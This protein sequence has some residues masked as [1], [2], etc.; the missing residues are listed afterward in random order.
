MIQGTLNHAEG[1]FWFSCV[2]LQA[3]DDFQTNNLYFAHVDG[4]KRHLRNGICGRNGASQPS[5]HQSLNE[6]VLLDVTLSMPTTG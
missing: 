3:F 1:F 6:R 2:S 4:L 5:M